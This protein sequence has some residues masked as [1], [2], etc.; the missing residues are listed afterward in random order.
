MQQ[1]KQ[2]KLPQKPETIDP[3]T[4]HE[5]KF[6]TVQ[7]ERTGI[8]EEVKFKSLKIDQ[9]ILNRLLYHVGGFRR[10]DI[11]E[12]PIFIRLTNNRLIKQVQIVQIQDFIFDYIDKLPDPLPEEYGIALNTRAIRKK[13]IEGISG[14]FNANKLYTLKQKEPIEFNRDT[15]AAKYIYF[16]NGFV[17]VTRADIQLKPYSDLQGYIWENEIIQ[18]DFNVLEQKQTG[19]VK[20]FFY[21][22]SGQKQNRYKDLC[23]IAGY[24]THTFFDTKLKSL[25]LTDSM[26]DDS[27][28]ANGRTGKTLFTR[29]ISGI[30]SSNP[31][32]ET[33]KTYVEINGKD[34]DPREKHKYSRA[35]LD[36]K[37]IHINDLKRGFDVDVLYNDITDG[38][39][40]DKKGL[41]PYK[42]WAKIILSTNKSLKIEGRS[43]KDRFIE[44]EFS[45]YFS[46][47]H[48]PEDEYK[49]WFFRDWNEKQ[50]NEYYNFMAHCCHVYMQ[51]GCK[52][53][54]PEQINL[55]AR[56]LVD[57][58]APEFA[59]WIQAFNPEPLKDYSKNEMFTK[60][61]SDYTDFAGDRFKQRT[62]TK[63]LITY[64]NLSDRWADYSAKLNEKRTSVDRYIIFIEK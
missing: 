40:V 7:T 32:D 59:E 4:V 39:T 56:K 31:L 16:K 64:I 42:I 37:L 11:E 10:M 35:A 13:M 24:Y 52:L 23:T 63:W 5:Y 34:F 44:Y 51:A 1:A 54:E 38:V 15:M 17:E 20:D 53:P 58:T 50:F 43:S 29:L 46:D 22:V 19:V 26:L 25:V 41:Q 48:S 57:L 49:H 62:F 30:L 36:T 33:I 2:I 55:N 6:W 12:T 60:F 18:H 61:R 27:G 21:K 14:Y 3:E 47:T 45:D 9:E 28:T 8:G